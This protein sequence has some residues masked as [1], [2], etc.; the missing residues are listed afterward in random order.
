MEAF[1]KS[2]L[3]YAEHHSTEQRTL[4]SRANNAGRHV[5]RLL[6]S[7]HTGVLRLNSRTSEC[8]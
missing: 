4:G 7:H 1:I 6:F 2:T 5:N 3:Q 8:C